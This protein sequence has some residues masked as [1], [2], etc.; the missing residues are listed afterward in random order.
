MARGSGGGG[1][2][3]IVE[4]GVRIFLDAWGHLDDQIQ[5]S[6]R[7]LS[8]FSHFESGFDTCGVAIESGSVLITEIIENCFTSGENNRR[9]SLGRSISSTCLKGTIRVSK[10]RVVGAFSPLGSL[11]RAHSIVPIK[12]ALCV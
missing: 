4:E 1:G 11:Q 12:F 6:F 3:G 10:G 7:K 8:F 9:S 5:G 2:G